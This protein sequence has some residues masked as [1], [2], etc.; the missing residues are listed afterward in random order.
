MQAWYDSRSH[1]EVASLSLFSSLENAV[2]SIGLAGLDRL[3]GLK[4][5]TALQALTTFLDKSVF[6]DKSWVA[7][8]ENLSNSLNPTENAIARPNKFYAEIVTLKTRV[9][10]VVLDHLVTL[11]QLQLLRKHVAYRLAMASKFDAKVLNSALKA[12]NK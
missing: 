7:M 11:G 1:N 9:C 6:R 10:S 5:V 12:F 3:L 2:G 4:A 8:L